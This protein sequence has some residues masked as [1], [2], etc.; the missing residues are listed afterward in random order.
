MKIATGGS[1]DNIAICFVVL[2][3]VQIVLSWYGFHAIKWV[4]SL[5]S[6]VILLALIYVFV[7]LI[8]DYSGVIAENWVASKR[9]MGL[10]VLRIHHGVY[11]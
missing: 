9:I 6:V 8:K 4:E 5:I 7:I 10:T 11:G 1:F 3:L 2:Q